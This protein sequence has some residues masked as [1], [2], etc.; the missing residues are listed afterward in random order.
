[1]NMIPEIPD[2][3]VPLEKGYYHGG[4]IMLHFNKYGG[5]DREEDQADMD[6]YPD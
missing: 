6:P 2:E 5:V 3:A 4:Y 1:M